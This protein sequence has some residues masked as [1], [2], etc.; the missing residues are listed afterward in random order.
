M[1]FSIINLGCK[2]N[3]VEADGCSASAGVLLWQNLRL[4][5]SS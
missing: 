1:K 2:V 5:S 4:T 3:R